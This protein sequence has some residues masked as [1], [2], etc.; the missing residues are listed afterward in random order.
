M[1][2]GY[3][4]GLRTVSR[5]AG[6]R[7]VSQARGGRRGISKQLNMIPHIISLTEGEKAQVERKALYF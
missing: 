3:Y 5:S 7:F 6:H 1:S 2:R 4:S